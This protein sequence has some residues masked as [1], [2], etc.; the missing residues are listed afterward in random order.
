MSRAGRDGLGSSQRSDLVFVPYMFHSRF[1][2]RNNMADTA[3][4]P[5][6]FGGRDT[7]SPIIDDGFVQVDG[8]THIINYDT[9]ILNLDDNREVSPGVDT[10]GDLEIPTTNTD[11]LEEDADIEVNRSY[12]DFS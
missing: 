10:D 3:P 7:I 5:M 9:D 4:G 1:Q 8:E 11:S 2:V 6:S 12:H